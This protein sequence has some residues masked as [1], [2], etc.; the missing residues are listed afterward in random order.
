MTATVLTPRDVAEAFSGHRFRDVYDALAPDVRWTAVGQ[1]ETVGREAVVEVCEA[2]LAELASGTAEFSRFV[3]VAEGDTVAVDS[4]AR[5]VDADGGV[6]VVS[7]CDVYAFTS[8]LVTE[9]RSYAVEL[10]G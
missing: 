9:I 5:Y 1:G 10:P 7:S 3:V 8:G 4:I 6:S 2:T